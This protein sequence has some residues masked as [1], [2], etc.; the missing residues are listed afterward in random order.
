MNV[1]VKL[2]VEVSQVDIKVNI[3]T[4]AEQKRIKTT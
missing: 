3:S 4:S 2:Y 1:E